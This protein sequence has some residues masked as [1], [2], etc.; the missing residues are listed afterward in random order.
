MWIKQLEVVSFGKWH[1]K[2][3]D[4]TSGFNYLYGSNESGKSSLR[5]FIT[6]I[7]FGLSAS[8]REQYT[9]IFDGQLGGRII[10][11]DGVKEYT[12]ER[13]SH[14]N[15]GKRVGYLAGETVQDK[16]IE[17]LLDHVDHYIYQAIFSFQDR[18]LEAIRHQQS[19]DIG[20]VLF[21]L[22][23]TGSEDIVEIEQGLTKESDKLF[24]KQ[25]R[26]PPVN[27]ALQQ[28]KAI[29][30][31][32]EKAQI[33]EQEHATLY[34]EAK[35]LELDIQALKYEDEQ[36]NQ[37]IKDYQQL[38]QVSS[39]IDR[40]QLLDQEMA[41]L[42]NHSHLSQDVI[43]RY[44]DVKA[45]R[46]TYDD[47]ARAIMA[48]MSEAKEERNRLMAQSKKDHFPFTLDEIQ[49]WTVE[50]EHKKQQYDDLS[51]QIQ[52]K[53]SQLQKLNLPVDETEL[54]SLAISDYT[55]QTWSRI[56]YD[57]H[58]NAEKLS[59]LERRKRIKLD[60]LRSLES[61]QQDVQKNLL[62]EEERATTSRKL[63]QINQQIFVDQTTASRGSSSRNRQSSLKQPLFMVGKWL[64]LAFAIGFVLAGVMA[65]MNVFSYV[66]AGISGIAFYVLLNRQQI[67][68]E[69]QASHS[70]NS[71]KVSLEQ[72]KRDL[73]RI[74]ENDD[75]LIN[76]NRDLQ[77]KIDYVN[78]ELREVESERLSI[79][80]IIDDLEFKQNQEINQ[81]QWL[82]RY[83]LEQWEDVAQQLIN[84]KHILSDIDQL[85][86]S[87]LTI[88]SSLDYIK[89]QLQ[90]FLSYYVNDLNWRDDQAG[91][92]LV[93]E[94]LNQER[95]ITNQINQ[96]HYWLEELEKQLQE[97][98]D[99]YAPY[100]QAME[101]MLSEIDVENE[102]ELEDVIQAFATYQEKD[103]KRAE[104]YEAV[105]QLFGDST[106]EVIAQSYNWDHLQEV[107]HDNRHRKEI[108]EAQLEEK[109]QRLA[110][111]T[112]HIRQIEEDGRL[113][114][115]IHERSKIEDEIKT[116]SKQ[117]AALNVA[118]GLIQD[119]KSRYQ[120][121]YLPH[122]LTQTSQL[123]NKLT[124]GIYQTVRFSQ[125]E[126]LMVQRYDDIWFDVKQLSDGT[127]DQLYVAL[128]F[129]LNESLRD[130][131]AFP[132]ILDDAFVHFDH[133]RK[134]EMMRILS[135]QAKKQQIIYFSFEEGPSSTSY[136]VIHLN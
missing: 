104:A 38:L 116:L 131:K 43:D 120:Y 127:A 96:H 48:K 59:D 122:V 44:E 118:K 7:L 111:C 36:L 18:D 128:R 90:R 72:E 106:N 35:Q 124:Q 33:K 136:H 119:T 77:T 126:S 15:R 29:N 30:E 42:L 6:Y 113:S 76:D 98:K 65:W 56:A 23:L 26:K 105:K 92:S 114:D 11:T 75:Q 99:E 134:Q 1:Q 68:I 108:G 2:T 97:L 82:E 61:K 52:S 100:E 102:A 31:E 135:Q 121:D 67:S 117:W 78:S 47:R 34:Q 28:L 55:K 57:L 10:L 58:A 25:G 3:I 86:E 46:Q 4:L 110:D 39:S 132:F 24:K 16:E 51:N 123:F 9:S 89:E 74:I 22:G 84:A 13:F 73:E 129:A 8:E 109:R 45:K 133:E 80:E 88:E 5:S 17:Q 64:A 63:E 40:V 87:Q 125:E 91:L 103:Q 60:E 27:Q 81:H 112:A 49:A 37:Q 53:R 66:Y 115:L 32:I 79:E 21:N 93:R 94:Y 69:Q 101:D 85:V 95:D 54:R 71:E 130:T 62:T 14:R 50:W 70:D 12:I 107:L 41:S 20:K 83:E 19:D